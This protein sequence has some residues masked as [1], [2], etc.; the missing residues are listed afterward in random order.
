MPK[1][2]FKLLSTNSTIRFGFME[3]SGA[4]SGFMSLTV[5]FMASILHGFNICKFVP[6]VTFWRGLFV[7][8]FIIMLPFGLC[9]TVF[10]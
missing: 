6:V 9:L 7:K 2:L 3:I 4:L 5:T 8:S 10:R 1:F